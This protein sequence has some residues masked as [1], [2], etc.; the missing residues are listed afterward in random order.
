M[1]EFIAPAL[2]VLMSEPPPA[3][4]WAYEIKFDGYRML[5]RVD[6]GDVR[7]YTRNGHDWTSKLP[8]LTAVLK[9]LPVQRAWLDAEA[10]CFAPD[11][12]PNFS[13]LQEAFNSRRTT[14]ICLVVFDLMWIDDTDLR[15]RP[16]HER[17]SA[18]TEIIA[19]VLREEVRFSEAIEADAAAM[20]ASACELGLEGIIGKQ[21]DAPYRSGRSDRWI[22]LKCVRRQEFVIGGFSRRKGATAGVRALLLGVYEEG[23][24]LRYVGHVAPSFTP[25]QAR[26]LRVGSR[27]WAANARRLPAPPTLRSIVSFTG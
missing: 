16:W 7:F 8:H 2:A 1:P 6:D 9:R 21:I 25:R 12:R 18:L 22:K 10:V 4:D 13:R 26:E 17:R 3:G 5:V 14:G 24:R 20:L 23:G 27:R 11:G 15:R 19:E